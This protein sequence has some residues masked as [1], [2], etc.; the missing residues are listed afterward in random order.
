MQARI[1][2]LPPV[3][4]LIAGA[5]AALLTVG[6]ASIYTIDTT[7]RAGQDGP[8]NAAKQSVVAVLGLALMLVVIRAGY[9]R[10]GKAAYLLFALAFL[11]LIPLLVAKV[12]GQTFGGLIAPRKGAF[13]WILLPGFALQPS[14]VMKLCYVIALAWYLRFRKNYRTFNG[15]LLPFVLSGPPLALVLMQPDLGTVILI[16]IVLFT[17]MYMAGARLTHLGAVI[18]IA[19]VM[20]PIAWMNIKPYQ[21]SRITTIL[22]QSSSLREAIIEQPERYAFLATAEEASNWQI[23]SGYQLVRSKQ[24][25]GSGGVFGHGWG[26]GTFVENALLPDCHND[27]IFAMIGHQWG[28]VG[29]MF[30]LTCFLIIVIAGMRIASATS[31]PFGRMLAVGIVALIASEVIINVGM[32]VGLM[33]ITGMSLPFVSAGGSGLLIHFVALALLMS[34]SQHQPY[35]LSPKPFEHRLHHGPREKF[36]DRVS[37][38]PAASR[39]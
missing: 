12:T 15:L 17:M 21:R 11:G 9:F 28:M 29:S 22:L 19:L 35:L 24:A 3:A 25:T 5:T 1:P 13:R 2:G 8:Y 31:E 23:D 20:A 36:A 32:T 14:E 38:V 37:G 30:V 26:E 7:Y 10:F 4:W 18:A 27:F 34:V 39:Q 6:V 16:T 33:P